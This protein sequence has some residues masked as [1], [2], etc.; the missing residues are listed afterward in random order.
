MDRFRVPVVSDTDTTRPYGSGESVTGVSHR[1]SQGWM[2]LGTQTRTS[3]SSR[4]DTV[5]RIRRCTSGPST[6]RTKDSCRTPGAVPGLRSFVVEG[7]PRSSPGTVGGWGWTSRGTRSVG[8]APRHPLRRPGG[9]VVVAG[10]G[11]THVV[12]GRPW[13]RSADTTPTPVV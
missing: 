2:S 1:S 3:V 13:T 11:P 8:V 5:R 12:G 6:S 4:A 7:G 10:G 9:P